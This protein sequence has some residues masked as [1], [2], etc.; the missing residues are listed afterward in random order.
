L[1][2]ALTPPAVPL[3]AAQDV[4]EILTKCRVS[5]KLCLDDERY[6]NEE[7]ESLNLFAARFASGET[8]PPALAGEQTKSK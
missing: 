2:S 5:R 7:R 4:I 8:L 1:F 3:C 6:A